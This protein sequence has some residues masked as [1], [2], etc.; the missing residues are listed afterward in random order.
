MGASIYVPQ[1]FI[2]VGALATE[3]LNQPIMLTMMLQNDGDSAWESHVQVSPQAQWLSL[4]EIYNLVIPPHCI[5]R[6]PLIT[7]PNILKA[8]TKGVYRVANVLLFDRLVV[9]ITAWMLLIDG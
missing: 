3:Q 2:W 7:Q 4:N 5:L 9:S 1:P 6:L 8:M